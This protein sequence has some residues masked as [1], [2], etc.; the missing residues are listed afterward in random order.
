MKF[1]VQMVPKVNLLK[2]KWLSQACEA[3]MIS[4]IAGVCGPRFYG[5]RFYKH[6]WCRS[7]RPEDD[8]SVQSFTEDISP[9]PVV[10][11]E[12]QMIQRFK[13]FQKPALLVRSFVQMQRPIQRPTEVPRPSRQVLPW[14]VVMMFPCFFLLAM[15]VISVQRWWFWSGDLWISRDSLLELG[16]RELF[17]FE[18]IHVWDCS[19]RPI[20]RPSEVPRPSRRVFA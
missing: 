11:L 17:R 19:L 3:Q 5:P 1:W 10:V 7:E 18:G 2:E 6:S 13:R 20:Q 8:I 4:S 16:A 9:L 15:G 12:A 14:N